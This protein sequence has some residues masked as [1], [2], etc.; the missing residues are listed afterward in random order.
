M[1][2]RDAC[3][4][5]VVPADY[6]SA[7]ELLCRFDS[8]H[9]QLIESLAEV[10]DEELC[11]PSIYWE[12]EPVDLRFRMYRFAW[13]LRSHIMQAD[14]IRIGIGHHTTDTDRLARLLYSALG[15]AE[16]TLIGAGVG[17]QLALVLSL[18]R[19]RAAEGGSHELSSHS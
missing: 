18:S 9:D 6:G 17:Q 10:S 2:I 12:D 8:C 15:E 5:S 14:K 19:R 13:H 3:S 16:G 1:P 11:T 4:E 7:A